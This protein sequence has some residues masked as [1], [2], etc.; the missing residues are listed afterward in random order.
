MR[1]TQGQFSFLPELTD[2]EILLQIVREALRKALF[3][4]PLSLAVECCL[5][6]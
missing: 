2:D 6:V 1:I 4:L 3:P 5:L